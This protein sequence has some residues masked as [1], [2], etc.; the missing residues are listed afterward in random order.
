MSEILFIIIMC[1]CWTLPFAVFI[2][3]WFWMMLA[4]D[5]VF[6]AFELWN[7]IHYGKT[8]SRQFWDWSVDKAGDGSYRNLWKVILIISLML[9]GWVM[10]LIH[11]LWRVFKRK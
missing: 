6:A 10:L 4:I 11:L 1:A 5:G 9:I 3:Q 2:P 8:L 7:K